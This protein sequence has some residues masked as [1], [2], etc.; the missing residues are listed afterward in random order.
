ML[1]L[2]GMLIFP[3]PWFSEKN[4]IPQR[5]L[6][7][8]GKIKLLTSHEIASSLAAWQ[9]VGVLPSLFAFNVR[10]QPLVSVTLSLILFDLLSSIPII[11]YYM[12]LSSSC[13]HI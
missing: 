12:V 7:S 5:T 2:Y 1:Q 11:L 4:Y 10:V 9:C 8:E 13:Y 6:C 3:G